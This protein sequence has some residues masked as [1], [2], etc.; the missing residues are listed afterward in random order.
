M[1]PSFNFYKFGGA[2]EAYA[3][4]FRACQRELRKVD[5]V[6]NS[7]WG[8]TRGQFGKYGVRPG[9]SSLG[10]QGFLDA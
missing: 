7:Q 3:T 6:L 9:D 1:G 2:R 5:D 10:D 4:K 8:E